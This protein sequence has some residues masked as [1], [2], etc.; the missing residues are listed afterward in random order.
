MAPR[1]CC[2]L[3][4][5]SLLVF[6]VASRARAGGEDRCTLVG[7]SYLS[8]SCGNGQCDGVSPDI[9]NRWNCARDCSSAFVMSY[10]SEETHCEYITERVSPLTEAQAIAAIN[11]ARNAGRHV[12]FAGASHSANQLICN[13]GTVINSANMREIYGLETFQGEE[14]VRVDGGVTYWELVNWLRTNNRA[15]DMPVTGFGG[16]TV[17]GALGTGAHG[18]HGW[19]YSSLS[20]YVRSVRLVKADGTVQEYTNDGSDTWRALMTNLGALGYVSQLRIATR[21]NFNIHARIDVF[22]EGPL[23]VTNGLLNL[24]RYQDAWGTIHDCK[25]FVLLWYPGPQTRRL[26]RFC[27]WEANPADPHELPLT[28]TAANILIA[29]TV[30]PALQATFRQ[31]LQRSSC[32]YSIMSDNER[33]QYNYNSN[34]ANSPLVVN[35]D[36]PDSQVQ[37]VVEIVGP[38]HRM[39]EWNFPTD[40]VEW[41]STDW[42]ITVPL[43]EFDPMVNAVRDYVRTHGDT[44]TTGMSFQAIGAF[45]R[46]DQ[47]DGASLLGA[48]S[49]D[50]TA[51]APN[52]TYFTQGERVVHFEV[53]TFAPWDMDVTARAAYE[54]NWVGMM[55]MILSNYHVRPHWGKNQNWAFA[56]PAVTF[57]NAE[58]RARFQTVLNAFDPNGLFARTHLA[59]AGFTWPNGGNLD[60]DG[61]GLNQAAEVAGGSNPTAFNGFR[62]R[63]ARADPAG[64]CKY[65]DSWSELESV[66]STANATED[67]YLRSG[68]EFDASAGNQG[69]NFVRNHYPW[70]PWPDEGTGYVTWGAR[71]S[72]NFNFNQTGTWCF[73]VNNG[74]TGSDIIGG[75]NA[76]LNL[77]VNQARVAQ[78]GYSTVGGSGGSPRTGCVSITT[79]GWRRLDVSGRYHDANLG[80]NYR[81]QVRYCRTTGTSCTPN[82]PIPQSMVQ[83]I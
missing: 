17:A 39:I 3:L 31:S 33:D 50:S 44:F 34:P 80:R 61:D 69:H 79:P 48:N 51:S 68:W 70:N 57:E 12:V 64:D 82:L 25:Y 72:G 81:M 47:A 13:D 42:E 14:V 62:M 22:P 10:Y 20:H 24:T 16:I 7:S 26:I 52:G 30:A 83:P 6:C 65:H 73:S 27:G 46:V 66:Y 32:S 55:Q 54:Q 77:W 45:I 29:P 63:L 56:F 59:N 74:A 2:A 71:L 75:R 43:D 38:W 15:L 49:V 4:A 78:T 35:P 1:Y 23:F 11:S 37:H 8:T 40:Q 9:E 67:F 53:P 58:R 21:S 18:T 5:G 76:C 19:G 28:P 60:V 41:N 36:L